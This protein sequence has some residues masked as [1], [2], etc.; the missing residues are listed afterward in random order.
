MVSID[1]QSSQ[2][3]LHTAGLARGVPSLVE[4][5]LAVLVMAAVEHPATTTV[6]PMTALVVCQPQPRV[7][8]KIATNLLW[9]SYLWAIQ[10]VTAPWPWFLAPHLLQSEAYPT[11]LGWILQSRP[12]RKSSKTSPAVWSTSHRSGM[13]SLI[14]PLSKIFEEVASWLS[15]FLEDHHKE[16]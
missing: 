16:A 7:S 4:L 10:S 6:C 2:V 12:F 9:P 11:D 5:C 1:A 13:N 14:M 8:S 15:C 3:D